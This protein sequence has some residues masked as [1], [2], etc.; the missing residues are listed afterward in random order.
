MTD[1]V[2]SAGAAPPSPHDPAAAERCLNCRAPLAG[3]F[4]QACGQEARVR[5][6]SLRALLADWLRDAVHLDS[7]GVR[8]LLDLLFR[9]G[10]M[11]AA[12]SRGE[13]RRYLQP[14]Q[15]YFVAAAL[16]FLV[17]ALHPFVVVDPETLEVRSSLG[18]A[19]A[20]ATFDQED[21]ALARGVSRELFAERFRTTV[22][23]QLPVFLVAVVAVFALVLAAFHPLAQRNLLVHTV[24]SLH[25]TAF[26]LLLMMLDR[27]L[28]IA[29]APAGATQGAL[30]AVALAY[31]AVAVRTVY[32]QR[33]IVAAAKAVGLLLVF[34][35]LLGAWVAGVT[36]FA[37]G[38]I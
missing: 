18:I 37:I 1:P 16:F 8:T 23:N 36:A 2:K 10:H 13:R 38:R 6:D 25:F 31:L 22:S 28:L 34:N 15:L 17:N 9:P 20:S 29:G 3:R 30:A 5:V 35:V 24:F 32:R 33:R 26:F 12:F 14:V 11:T 7:R 21:I 19:G 4:C 27:L